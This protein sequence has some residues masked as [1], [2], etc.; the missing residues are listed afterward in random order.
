MCLVQM[1]IHKSDFGFVSMP[2]G[3]SVCVC[4]HAFVNVFTEGVLGG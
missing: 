1:N 2:L 3:E 4:M